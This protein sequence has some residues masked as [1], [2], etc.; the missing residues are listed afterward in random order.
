M[1]S[2]STV[3]RKAL[4][5][6]L[7][8]IMAAGAVMMPG[9]V[10]S[11]VTAAADGGPVGDVIFNEPISTP[12]P[13]TGAG[14][15]NWDIVDHSGYD[16]AY[17]QSAPGRK[18]TSELYNGFETPDHVVLQG[19][20]IRFFGYESPAYVDSVF[21]DL[22]DVRGVSFILRPVNMDFHSFSEAG[23]LFNGEFDNTGTTTTYTGYA[24]VLK[25]GNVAGMQENDASAVNKATL[26][27]YYIDNE[28]W[29]SGYFQ[30]GNVTGSRTLVSVLKTGI[31][32]KD[33][34]P[35]RVSLE[36]DAYRAFNLY[37]DGM[38]RSSV[39]AADV[40]G[41]AV[42]PT[43]FGFYT[44]YY[45]HGCSILTRIYF[46][47]TEFDV[48]F[49]L[50]DTQAEVRFVD[51]VGG[52]EIRAPEAIASVMAGQ[53]YRIVQPRYIYS[54]VSGFI[55]I[56]KSNSR[57]ASI[58]SDIVLTYQTNPLRNTTTLFY[59][60]KYEGD[61]SDIGVKNA[62]VNDEPWNSGSADD[63][64]LVGAED[65]V[66]YQITVFSPP[67]D[68]AATP[69]G[70]GE[71][72]DTIPT[73]MTIDE[74]GITGVKS[75][76]PVPGAISWKLDATGMTITW[77]IP[78]GMYPVT[79]SARAVVNVWQS[80][81]TLYVNSASVQAAAGFVSTDST[82]HV[83]T[84][85]KITEQYYEYDELAGMPTTNKLPYP[86]YVTKY[87]ELED[88][89]ARGL[90]EPQVRMYILKGFDIG[91]G[92]KEGI[93]DD[94]Y[95]Y[96]SSVIPGG[97]RPAGT[98]DDVRAFIDTLIKEWHGQNEVW[99]T[100]RFYYM[101]V[102]VT[103]HYADENGDPINAPSF[104]AEQVMPLS[105]Y[106]IKMASFDPFVFNGSKWN[107]Y[108]YKLT[109]PTTGVDM[110]VGDMAVYPPAGPLFPAAGMDGS[111]HV[112]LYFT[113]RQAVV[114]NF[115]EYK[116]PLNILH[117]KMTFFFDTD[118]DITAAVATSPTSGN[119]LFDDIDLTGVMGKVYQYSGFYT[120]DGGL[121]QAGIPGLITSACEI[122]LFFRT[123]YLLIEKYHALGEDGGIIEL[124]PDDETLFYGGDPF[125]GDPPAEIFSADM[126]KKYV[127]KGYKLDNDSNPL[128]E[129]TPSISSMT[130]DT[131]IIYVYELELTAEPS[132][133][134]SPE[135]PSPSPELPSPSPSTSPS[136]SPS[137]QPQTPGGGG[138]GG[139]G[140]GTI[141]TQTSPPPP[142]PSPSPLPGQPQ[143]PAPSMP[144]T[145]GIGDKVP[146]SPF[147][148]DH[149][150]YIIGYP[151]GDVRPERNVSRAETATVFFRL[152]TDEI[153]KEYWT[154]DNAFSDSTYSDWYNT[155]VSVMTS[156]G[157]IKGYPDGLFRPDG[158]I[159]RAELATIAARFAGMM[160]MVEGE[161]LKFNDIS[162][163]WAEAS[164]N[165]A[166]A[167]G[168]VNGYPDGSFKPEQPITRAEFMTLVNRVMGREPESADDLL[169]GEMA[170]WPDNS[171]TGAWYY[172]AVQEATNSHI[173][174]F[175]AKKVPRLDFYYEYWVEM[176]KNRD[177]LS[178][179]TKW[180]ADYS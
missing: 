167:I 6:A 72:R 180:I 41:G 64:V 93:D 40:E 48:N 168:W 18:G 62:R 131:V 163:H 137:Q 133:S 71:I 92:F 107:Y 170:V 149:V 111:K 103:I 33:S 99:N 171:D 169:P 36:V 21:T 127:Y 19:D 1:I 152:L 22:F 106:Y 102:Y 162:G 11:P 115:K 88:Y 55:Y 128:N 57:Y 68:P 5:A 144:G 109:D 90:A 176:T 16:G 15:L 138:G 25:C 179:E 59:E 96:L 80:Q 47:N 130:G 177:W 147:I 86:Y 94:V 134:P 53:R 126:T 49:E 119:S 8:V 37:V 159:T 89:Q 98:V 7:A 84:P 67:G 26:C 164:I 139:G 132:P 28:P 140:G 77:S 60:V 156:M 78:Y 10:F 85:Y 174:E 123:Q 63:P 105:D 157:V 151:E 118:F 110:I 81:G 12:Q 97:F 122:T 56:L 117:N 20:D 161:A 58:D 145:A 95:D 178:L 101:P 54:S 153:R 175:K 35:F 52:G 29:N 165:R 39:S 114:V 148:S 75:A 155:A 124:A 61:I 91:R 4:S 76:V 45:G 23:F 136:T 27:L 70:Y 51:I 129:G 73:G 32:N 46:E 17:T 79:V 141:S 65:I 121:G 83:Y 113:D 160:Q 43:G 87:K 100:V 120:I 104:I 142:S 31:N 172:L 166:A 3:F 135:L 82:Y 50:K 154:R 108:D 69:P 14:D 116:N 146:L 44:G 34:T 150:A 9:S 42:G 30:P 143:T 112:T 173:P 38:L 24:L 74:T 13:Y 2:R 158:D 66:E 125:A